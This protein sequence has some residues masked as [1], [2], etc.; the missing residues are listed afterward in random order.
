MKNTAI[1]YTLVLCHSLISSA[2]SGK[3]RHGLSVSI[4]GVWTAPSAAGIA[5]HHVQKR[6]TFNVTTQDTIYCASKVLEYE[7]SSNVAQR[8]ADIALGCNNQALARNTANACA[9][10]E[11]GELCGAATTR[12]M[13]EETL[14][15]S[16]CYGAVGVGVCP[17][18]CRSFLEFG[19]SQL[20]CCINTY[21]NV[22]GSSLYGT[23][24]DYHLWNLC[25]VELPPATGCG[26]SPV[27]VSPT[28]SAQ[29][30]T[31]AEYFT[32]TGQYQCMPRVGQPLVDALLSNR[33]CYPFAKAFVDGCYVNPNGQFCTEI[34]SSYS[35]LTLQTNCISN[36][37]CSSSCRSAV[38]NITRAYGCCVNVYNTSDVGI[39]DPSLSYSVWS[40]CG[41]ESPGFCTSTLNS[42]VTMKAFAWIISVTIAV[43]MYVN[44]YGELN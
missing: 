15:A 31:Q 40:S 1:V 30:C 3:S 43:A 8:L 7:C 25:N 42:S 19:R 16:L 44:Y 12:V 14:N 26:N 24:V 35:L 33:R 11:R 17:S 22:T 18:T 20:G 9:R 34:V 10:S 27:T 13:L 6:Q 41:V 38:T 23:Y 28:A 2:I 37:T 21:I 29:T 32:R 4:A 36:S 5:H 39:Q